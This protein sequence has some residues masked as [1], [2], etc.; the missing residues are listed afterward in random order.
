MTLIFLILVNTF[1]TCICH[2]GMAC[3]GIDVRA[4]RDIQMVRSDY[5]NVATVL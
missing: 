1:I 5:W 3:L 4:I 2:I